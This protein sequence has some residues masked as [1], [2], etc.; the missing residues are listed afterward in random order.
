[1]SSQ[2]ITIED[3]RTREREARLRKANL[4]RER[5]RELRERIAGLAP[6]DGAALVASTL[7]EVPDYT[8][9]MRVGRLL[10]A[11]NGFGEDRARKTAGAHTT[12]QLGQLSISKRAAIAEECEFRA[13]HLKTH[14][15]PQSDP[16][17]ALQALAA[18][19]RVRLAR[20]HALT[21]IAKAPTST[22][23]A[24]RAAAL[25]SNGARPTDLGGLTVRAVLEAIP[26]VHTEIARKIMEPLALTD[27]SRLEMLSRVR[28]S[29]VAVDLIARSQHV[30]FTSPT[31]A[32][33]APPRGTDAPHTSTPI[34]PHAALTRAEAA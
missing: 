3:A 15:G 32:N 25:I 28:A 17:L 7:L 27:T 16:E 26:G 1:M 2:T 5:R 11:I 21:Q 18:A 29:R 30:Q 6:P 4:V 13:A 31:T 24:W 14:R 34:A 33:P 23:G 8:R 22:L 12:S 9:S 10:R 20:A 19:D